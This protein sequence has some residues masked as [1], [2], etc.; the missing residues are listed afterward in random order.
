MLESRSVFKIKQSEGTIN[1]RDFFFFITSGLLLKTPKCQSFCS[2]VN[3]IVE[4]L[5]VTWCPTLMG[6]CYLNILRCS[7]K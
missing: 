7:L 2:I 4:T 3:Q 6:M 5:V 1:F